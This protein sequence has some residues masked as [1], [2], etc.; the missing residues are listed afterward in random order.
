MKKKTVPAIL[1]HLDWIETIKCLSYE[2]IGAFIIAMLDYANTGKD[3][4]FKD[5]SMQALFISFKKQIDRDR[6]SY[7]EKCKKNSESAKMR[8]AKE[9][10]S[11]AYE[12]M[13]TDA[14]ACIN[15]KNKDNNKSKIYANRRSDITSN[16]SRRESVHN[17]AKELI[18][19]LCKAGG[20]YLSDTKN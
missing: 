20:T 18:Q 4:K 1:I 11:D 2:Q 19:E 3:P 15:N 9:K 6:K 12:C 17:T 14:N 16:N 10:D 13:Q 8:W 5:N 7:E